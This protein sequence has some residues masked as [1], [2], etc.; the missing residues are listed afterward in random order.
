MLSGWRN[1]EGGPLERALLAVATV[2]IVNTAMLVVAAGVVT[3]P[4]G[5]VAGSE[6]LYRWRHHHEEYLVAT[7]VQSLRRHVGRRLAIGWSAL[8][9]CAWGVAV[10]LE[11]ISL[12]RPWRLVVPAVGVAELLVAVPAAWVALALAWASDAPTGP[13]LRSALLLTAQMPAAALGLSL[14]T[15]SVTVV[16]LADPLLLVVGLVALAGLAAQWLTDRGLARRG[17]VLWRPPADGDV[18]PHLGSPDDRPEASESPASPEASRAT[19]AKATPRPR[20]SGGLG[21]RPAN[22]S[23]E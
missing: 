19:S 10:V 9:A 20:N 7:F 14:V 16:V 18:S 17:V 6:T 5:L 15:L 4:L 22:R 8:G 21:R 13:I 3:L 12:V 23:G 11:G 2:L 1:R